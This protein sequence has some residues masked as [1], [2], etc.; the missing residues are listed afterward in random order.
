MHRSLW[1]MWVLAFAVDARAAELE[2]DLSPSAAVK[3]VLAL[4]PVATVVI[5]KKGSFVG[6][7]QR[8]T[9]ERFDAAAHG[10]LVTALNKRLS[11][12]VLPA[13]VAQSILTKE[14]VNAAAVD[15][16]AALA[17]VMK[18]ANVEWAIRFT[19]SRS[20]LLTAQVIDAEGK[21]AGESAVLNN[22]SPGLTDAQADSI[23]SFIEPRLV[24]IAKAR[25]AAAAAAKPVVEAPPPPPPDEELVDAELERLASQPKQ[26][27]W[28]PDRN[29]VRAL[30]ALGPGAALRG[31]ETSGDGA[32]GL[33]ELENGAVVGLGVAAQ[34]FPLELFDATGGRAWSQLS[35]EV[36][37][38]RAFVRAEGVAGSVAGTTCSMTDDDLQL[39]AGWRYRFGDGYLPTIGLAGGWSQEQ[40]KFD[41]SL[42]LVS[43]TWRGVDAQ[44]RIRQPLYRDLVT[45]ELIGGP[46]ILLP[47][48]LAESPGF[49][50][51]G[52][53]WVEVKPLSVLFARAGGRFSRLQASNATL[54]ATD[55][56]AFL[57]LELG[58]FF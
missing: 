39:R 10:K 33:A 53:A 24:S 26:T 29:R 47:G 27:A 15:T 32:A 34:L 14:G 8:K 45:L 23:A 3:G 41:C 19:I 52:E 28:A 12:R 44:L 25:A 13:D 4:P 58:A 54:S 36:N 40:T 6:V 55:S 46:R 51:S 56:R 57:A 18:A 16:P 2:L 20:N 50:L 31:F 35:I 11:D 37:Y 48:P 5:G 30:V 21:P 9:V 42:P 43:T 38:R 1:L 17:R 49:S 22:V 7:D